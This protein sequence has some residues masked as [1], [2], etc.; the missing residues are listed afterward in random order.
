MRG[1]VSLLLALAVGLTANLAQGEV[2]RYTDEQGRTLFT[3]RQMFNPKYKLVWRSSMGG[4][5]VYTPQP[6]YH[7]RSF[8]LK[9]VTRSIPRSK[10]LLLNR[11][12]YAPLIDK[13]ARQ[14]RLSADL[15]HAVILAESAYNP[16]AKS[17]AGA[18]GLMQLMPDTA[19]RYGVANV[20]DPVQNL[21]GGARYLRD[22]L[23][24][25]ENNLRLALAAYN[26]GE[27]A[28]KKY[29][30]RIPPYPETQDYV[31]K[32]VAYYLGERTQGRS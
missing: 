3:D 1:C 4:V 30:N 13:V 7:G 28:V 23:D 21:E 15:L 17:P 12:R 31:E 22:L 32:V 27:G 14:A 8:L 20:W 26:A 6:L 24:M 19:S 25:F 10:A 5:G 16:E 18:M 2:F 11:S 9:S 29:G